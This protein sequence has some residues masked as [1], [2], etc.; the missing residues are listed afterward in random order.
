MD[1]SVGL[2]FVEVCLVEVWILGGDVRLVWV[3]CMWI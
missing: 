3:R 1:V 2:F